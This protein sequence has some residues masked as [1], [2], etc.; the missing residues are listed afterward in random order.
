MRLKKYSEFES[1][2]ESLFSSSDEYYQ[3]LRE[4]SL[5]RNFFKDNLAYVEDID[6]ASIKIYNFI[7]DKSGNLIDKYNDSVEYFIR[8]TVYI[9]YSISTVDRKIDE[10][11]KKIDEFN[12]IKIAIEELKDRVAEEVDFVWE[13]VGCDP[14]ST[15][16]PITIPNFKFEFS[17]QFDSKEKINSKLKTYYDRF[18]NK[19]GPKH[20]KMIKELRDFYKVYDINFDDYIDIMEDEDMGLISIGVFPPNGDLYHVADYVSKTDSYKLYHDAL[21]D[22]IEGFQNGN[23][24]R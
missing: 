9:E 13:R 3:F 19:F 11:F 4:N 14:V 12:E 2:N 7:C 16:R 21:E 10:F 15:A 22:S 1:I 20:D 6:G 24:W 23:I 18:T 5:P 8:Y 17:L